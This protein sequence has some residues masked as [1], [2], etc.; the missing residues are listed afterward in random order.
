M[1]GA[2]PVFRLYAFVACT[3]TT[4]PFAFI[5]KYLDLSFLSNKKG[6]SS[7]ERLQYSL[8]IEILQLNQE[9]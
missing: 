7:F 1:S 3:W 2:I 9:T 6:W 5:K 4:L 8:L